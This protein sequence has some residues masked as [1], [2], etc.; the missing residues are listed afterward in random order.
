[1][2]DDMSILLMLRELREDEGLSR[3]SLPVANNSRLGLPWG[4]VAKHASLSN[5]HCPL[6]KVV[7]IP[8][9]SN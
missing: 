9:A 8:N 2:A 6:H 4:R 1:M 3:R 7:S 5:T